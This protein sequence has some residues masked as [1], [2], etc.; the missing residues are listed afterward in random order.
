MFFSIVI[1]LLI[2][3]CYVYIMSKSVAGK[4]YIKDSVG[5]VLCFLGKH[6]AILSFRHEGK[7]QRALLLYE[8]LK[9]NGLDLPEEGKLADYLNVG[10][11]IPFT[12]HS[13]D[14]SGPDK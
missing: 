1:I 11:T 7:D 6:K 5:S 13:F 3:F 2:L 9:F 10:S 4:L 8:K 14:D 12:C